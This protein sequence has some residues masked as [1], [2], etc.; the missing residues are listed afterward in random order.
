MSKITK[1]SGLVDQH[2]HGAFG[3]DF[4]N[5]DSDDIIDLAKQILRLGVTAIFPTL[6]TDTPENLKKQIKK[7]KTAAQKQ[8]L[9]SA[10]IEGIHIEGPFINP[11]KKG[12]HDDSKILAPSV[13]S[14]K[15]FEDD[16]IKIVTLAPELDENQE[17]IN[18]LKSKKIKV[19]A[20]HCLTHNLDCV[21]QVTHLF[22][23]MGADTHKEQSTASRA[24]IDEK[25][26]AELIADGIH[27]NDDILK[28][29]FKVKS[30]NNILLISDALP[31]AHSSQKEMEFCSQKVCLKDNKAVSPEGIIAGSAMLLSDIAT[32]LLQNGMLTLPDI[33]RAASQNQVKYHCLRN[34][35]NILWD[36]DYNIVG[37]ELL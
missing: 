33:L 3:I 18:Y 35:A 6:V 25:I 19:S 14:F 12:I 26:N 24:L 32:R 7:I 10:K 21:N 8:P 20:G 2:L 16:F 27:V 17:L 31:I 28:I 4:S 1:T 15:M 11:S 13:E 37:Y 22:N 30:I 9:D 23:A 29:V 5:A 36:E 34:R